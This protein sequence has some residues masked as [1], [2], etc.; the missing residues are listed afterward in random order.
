MRALV[1]SRFRWLKVGWLL[2]ALG[3]GACATNPPYQEMSDARQA[4]AAAEEAGARETSPYLFRL[5]NRHLSNART[6]MKE[7]RFNA[8]RNEAVLAHRKATEALDEL[9]TSDRD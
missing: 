2:V 5:A 4:V 6:A 9:Q 7:R 8:A 3:L 1:A